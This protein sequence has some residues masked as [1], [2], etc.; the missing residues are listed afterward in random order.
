[1]MASFI[2]NVTFF[3]QLEKFYNSS[4]EAPIWFP[5]LD[6]LCANCHSVRYRY[7]DRE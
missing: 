5:N 7:K 2:K 4:T 3:R 6:D 1:M